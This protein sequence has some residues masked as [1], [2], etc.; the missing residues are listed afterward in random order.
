MMKE[1]V[2]LIVKKL[3]READAVDVRE[4]ERE[5]STSVIEIRVA[6]GDVGKIIGRQGRTV[7]ALRSLLYAAGEKHRRR[8]VLEIVEE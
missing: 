6:Q 3:V 4:I 2:E 5:R 7:K 1:A 8:Y